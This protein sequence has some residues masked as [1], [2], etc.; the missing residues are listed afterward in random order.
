VAQLY[1]L[2]VTMSLIP[3]SLG[4]IAL[5]V[6]VCSAIIAWPVCFVRPAVLR[7][8]GAIFVPFILSYCIYWLPVWRGANPSEYSSWEALGIGA[9]FLAGLIAS[10]LVIV[11]VSRTHAKRNG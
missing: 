2:A 5:L 4:G 9:P 1:S 7:W 3:N 8:G 6:A 10:I 11:I